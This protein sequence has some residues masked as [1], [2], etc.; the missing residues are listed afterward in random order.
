MNNQGG[1]SDRGAGPKT[2]AGRNFYSGQ[3]LL[4]MSRLEGYA[5]AGTFAQVR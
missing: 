4:P 5:A 1:C 3:V 2:S